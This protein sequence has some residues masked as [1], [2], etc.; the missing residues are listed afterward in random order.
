M[1]CIQQ[2]FANLEFRNRIYSS[3]GQKF[4]DLFV[5][6]MD[7]AY[8]SFHAVKTQGS[9]GD[10]KNDGY[11]N[12]N[13][14]FYQVFGP[15]DIEKSIDDAIKKI[16]TD[17]T[18]LVKAWSNIN[19]ITYVVNDKYKGAK[20]MVHQKLQDLRDG[21]ATLSDV[22]NV[23][24]ILWTAKDLEN[25]FNELSELSKSTIIN[26]AFLYA[27]YTAEIDYKSLSEVVHYII[28]LETD[29]SKEKFFAPKFNEKIKFNK[30]SSEIS[31]R[32]TSFYLDNSELSIY[33][34]NIGGYVAES[35]R[36]KF[37]GIYNE[38]KSIIADEPTKNDQIYL[39]IRK[40]VCPPNPTIGYL[41]SIESLM[42]YYFETC[43]IFEENE[44]GAEDDLT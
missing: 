17:A 3:D 27:K 29:P 22:L 44:E 25:I 14:E 40:T 5:E 12:E 4:E 30:L 36:E 6:L 13:G 2:Y 39:Y 7:K 21:I 42:A 15:E 38:A 35:L 32:L 20:V 26:P 23:K 16:N 28:N 11:S 19:T 34:D 9:F 24:V 31:S 43:D 1:D 33:F 8:P 37:N 18:G 10:M 41:N